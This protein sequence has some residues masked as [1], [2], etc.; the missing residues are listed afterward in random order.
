MSEINFK[1]CLNTIHAI[2]ILRRQNKNKKLIFKKG[3]GVGCNGF[4]MISNK[5]VITYRIIIAVTQNVSRTL[6]QV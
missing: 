3:K 1:F 6:T 2:Q 4:K 5:I